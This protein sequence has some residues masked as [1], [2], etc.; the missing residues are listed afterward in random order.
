M[1]EKKKKYLRIF[2]AEAEEHL[3]TIDSG[4]LALEEGKATAETIHDIFRAAHTLKG[5]SRMLGLEEIG[6]IAHKMEDVLKA[7][8]NGEVPPAS[9]VID[10]LL[11]GNDAIEKLLDPKR[12]P[13]VDRDAVI[14]ALSRIMEGDYETGE[15]KKVQEV[16][17]EKPGEEPAPEPGQP[18]AGQ[19][20]EADSAGGEQP[21]AEQCADITPTELEQRG[22]DKG[23]QRSDTLRVETT[24]LDRL[25][26]LS[27]ELL[28]NKIKLES[29][30]FAARNLLDD[31]SEFLS[32]FD[33]IAGNGNPQRVKDR[34]QELRNSVHEFVQEFTEDVIDLDVNVQDVQSRALSLRMTP[35]STLFDE[36]PRM[37]R[38]LARDLEKSIK[39]NISGEDT[40]LDKRL[41][42]QLRGPLVHLIRNACDHGIEPPAER[43]AAGKPEAG[44]ITV[45]AYH[46]GATVVFEIVDDGRGMDP[47]RIREAALQ[48]GIIDERTAD[49]LTEEEVY[50]L[51]LTPGFSTSSLITDIS[52]RG[53]GMDVVK[54]N[55]ESLRGDMAI[56]SS[57]GKGT[58][59]EL[60]LPLTVSIIEALLIGQGGE[61]FS[62]PLT[63]V[64]EVVRV[65]VER[66]VTDR[67]REAL[68][69]RGQLLPLIR[70][71]D[72]LG[73]APLPGHDREIETDEDNLNVV[74][75]KFRNQRLALEV[76][77]SLR[78]Q[79]IMVK[80]LGSKMNKVPLVSGATI[81]RKGEPSLILNVFDI[82]AEAERM[83]GKKIKEAASVRQKK[84]SPRVLVVDDSITTRTIEK[85][86]L[87]RA[88]Y[89]VYTAVSAEEA[90]E[91][92]DETGW[93]FDV[94]VIDVDMPGMNGFE[95]TERLRADART[96]DTPVIICTSR[97][98]DEDK[99][100]GIQVG[101]QGY[102]VK[103]SF[104]QNVLL[105]TVKS[106]IGE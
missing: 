48:R 50:Y 103:G 58:R 4:L 100:R 95:L 90:I 84:A 35:A 76:D 29:R 40:E 75:L 64:D 12:A 1:D 20:P 37:V 59:I 67:G 46:H 42:E 26:D 69:V 85:N 19:E 24:R 105:D 14:D 93:N 8:E 52:G 74:V 79:E 6:G 43:A 53:V 98:T 27:G 68:P 32:A 28:I 87:E 5:S 17:P 96:A 72:L 18:A 51:T 71:G 78:E 11:A 15:L 23:T 60:K 3:A 45:Q 83:G 62:I 102:I 82:F 88:G 41:L 44:S 33:E 25:I 73:L 9:G 10:R 86:I 89:D 80:T 55:V 56:F 34:V 97:A 70:L 77:K 57:R 16:K 54:T 61:I 104:D 7:V 13:E 21:A 49:E 39:L 99:R 92:L 81:L 106:L 63:A 38:D 2:R 22:T 65:R 66:L 94:F 101:A 36:F 30:T 47:D 31:V 91:T